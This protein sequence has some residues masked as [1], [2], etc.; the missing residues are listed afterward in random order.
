MITD[1]FG[2]VI[3]V[4]VGDDKD[5]LGSTD[6]QA[7]EELFENGRIDRTSWIMN[8]KSPRVLTAEIMLKREA[9]S[10]H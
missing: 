9:T 6:H 5:R 8:R 3:R 4:V 2:L 1:E 7:L 10:S